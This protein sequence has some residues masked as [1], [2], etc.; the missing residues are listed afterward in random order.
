MTSSAVLTDAEAV[1]V[2]EGVITQ[3][4][5]PTCDAVD[6]ST[7]SETAIARNAEPVSV[8]AVRLGIIVGAAGGESAVAV[9]MGQADVAKTLT[10]LL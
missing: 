5:R 2:F 4:N 3:T 10:S 8:T 7:I 9:A 6:T 1:L